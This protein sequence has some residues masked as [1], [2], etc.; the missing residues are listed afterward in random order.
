[1]V[2]RKRTNKYLQNIT[3]KTKDWVTQTPLKTRCSRTVSSSSSNSGTC[4]VTL[5]TNS[6]IYH[7]WGKDW[8]VF[9]ASGTYLWHRYFNFLKRLVN[10]V[11]TLQSNIPGLRSVLL[12]FSFSVFVLFCLSSF[13]VLCPMLSVSLDSPFLISPLV[14]S[15]V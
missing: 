3:H 1:M 9:T 12:S 7:E 14:S 4:R 2:K 5:V 8:K 15:N 13:Y 6:M 10:S 11:K